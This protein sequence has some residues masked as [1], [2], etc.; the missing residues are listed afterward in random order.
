MSLLSGIKQ[1]SFLLWGIIGFKFF[2]FE[3]MV[4]SFIVFCF[5]CIIDTIYGYSLARQNLIVSSK[6][7]DVGVYRKVIQGLII[8][9]VVT[10]MWSLSNEVAS[11]EVQMMLSWLIFM[12]IIGFSFG[13]LTSIIEN[14][15]VSAHGKEL[16]F[17]NTLLKLAGIWQQKIDEKV[18]KYTQSKIV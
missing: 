4:V 8:L 11:K 1:S 17:I 3:F 6:S 13:Q 18:Q 16:W 5:L 14:M 7:W 12:M 15:A 10:L 9:C 2:G